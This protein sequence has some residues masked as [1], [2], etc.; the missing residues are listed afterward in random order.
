MNAI[1]KFDLDDPDDR[2]AHMRCVKALDMA[3]TLHDMHEMFHRLVNDEPDEARRESY[4]VALDAMN[5]KLDNRGV[6]LSELIC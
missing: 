6:I 1:L 2:Y 5:N 4:Q 3:L